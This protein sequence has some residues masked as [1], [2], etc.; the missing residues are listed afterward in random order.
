MNAPTI[1]V[2]LIWSMSFSSTD[3]PVYF[4]LF[5]KYLKAKL[6][7]LTISLGAMSVR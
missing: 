5:K 3:D 1:M 7:P 4:S 6:K 2:A